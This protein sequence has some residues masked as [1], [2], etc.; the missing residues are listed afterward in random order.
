MNLHHFPNQR[1]ELSKL[2]KRQKRK[3]ELNLPIDYFIVMACSYA[4]KG[5]SK[6]E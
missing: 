2:K 6:N 1:S 3:R 5:G 4:L